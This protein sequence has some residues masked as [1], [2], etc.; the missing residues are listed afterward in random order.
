MAGD[1]PSQCDARLAD[2]CLLA[3]D[4]SLTGTPLGDVRWARRLTPAYA[5]DIILATVIVAG[6]I[7]LVRHTLAASITALTRLNWA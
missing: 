6:G 5:A 4:A 1:S 7:V 3:G 2:D